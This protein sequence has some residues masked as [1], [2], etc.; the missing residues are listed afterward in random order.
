MAF[1]FDTQHLKPQVRELINKRDQNDKKLRENKNVILEKEYRNIYPL[2]IF[3]KLGFESSSNL[4]GVQTMRIYED[5]CKENGSTWFSTDSLSTGMSETKR[6]E[7]INAIKKDYIVEIYFA[8]G[9]SSGGN[10]DIKFKAE[11]IDVKTDGDK[12][13][14]PE[15]I[16]TPDEWKNDKNKIWIKVRCLKSITN[17][18]TKDFIVAS[19][20]NILADSIAHSQY[21]FGYIKK[22]KGDK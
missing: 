12:I 9:K 18:T 10:N 19:T 15:K 1:R 13:S 11:V 6:V 2:A 17:P 14:A 21:H 4:N 16:L 3:M 20:G 7:F 22:N 5:F 8:I